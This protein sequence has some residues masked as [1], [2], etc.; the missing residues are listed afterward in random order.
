[1]DKDSRGHV[2]IS[3][4]TKD[5]DAAFAACSFLESNGISCWIAP[6]NIPP[7]MQF[8][9]AI[10]QGIRNASMVLLMASKDSLASNQVGNEIVQAG[11]LRKA[12]LPFLIG[13]VEIPDNFAYYIGG[14]QWIEAKSSLKDH[15]P[16]LLDAVANVLE[17]AAPDS[18]MQGFALSNERHTYTANDRSIYADVASRYDEAFAWAVEMAQLPKRPIRILSIGAKDPAL[19]RRRI[20]ISGCAVDK[21]VCICEKEVHSRATQR[22]LGDLFDCVPIIIPFDEA[23]ESSLLKELES[24]EIGAIDVVFSDERFRKLSNLSALFRRLSKKLLTK[25]GAVILRSFDDGTKICYPDANDIMGYIISTSNNLV[26]TT[27]RESGRRLYTDLR[28]AGF[29]NIWINYVINDTAKMDVDE[30][31][32]LFEESFAYRIDYFKQAVAN[33]PGNELFERELET[34]KSKLDELEDMFC[35]DAFFYMETNFFAVAKR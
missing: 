31:I 34:M 16:Y 29:R 1:M 3:Y 4:S 21:L 12:I 24:L 11:A 8:P 6:R 5:S 13:D 18:D 33:H 14:T 22:D 9:E 27:D 20:E 2:F 32:A 30:R 10:V 26:G 17:S 7:A 25:D 23:F 35:D 19:I 15:F 28:K